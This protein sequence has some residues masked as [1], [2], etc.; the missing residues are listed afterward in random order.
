[1]YC[2]S[3]FFGVQL[4]RYRFMLI[5]LSAPTP[6]ELESNPI[7]LSYLPVTHGERVAWLSS[8]LRAMSWRELHELFP[9]LMRIFSPANGSLIESSPKASELKRLRG[10]T[11]K[12]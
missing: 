9:A 11:L 4:A 2:K 5:C 3:K 8:R 1:L 12:R 7:F 6:E 10:S